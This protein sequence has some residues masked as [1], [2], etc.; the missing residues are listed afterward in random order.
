LGTYGLSIVLIQGVQIVLGKGY[1]YATNPFPGAID[2]LGTTYPIYR[3]VLIAVAAVLFLVVVLLLNATP[4]GAKIRAVATDGKL[5]ETL[6]VRSSRLN[7]T[8]FTVSAA[9]A[10]LAG[11]LVSPLGNVRP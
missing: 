10:G 9:L 8:V 2:I 7:L 4:L 6:G 5:A 11:L 3:L 1:L